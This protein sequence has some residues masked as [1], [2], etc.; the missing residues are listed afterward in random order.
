MI[1]NQQTT[2]SGKEIDS[3]INGQKIDVWPQIVFGTY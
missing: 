1:H 3:V 2:E